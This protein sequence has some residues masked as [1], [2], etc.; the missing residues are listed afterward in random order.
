MQGDGT[1]LQGRYRV[2]RLE[3]EGGMSFVYK[4]E[5]ER[6]NKYWALK[7]LKAGVEFLDDSVEYAQFKTEARI[8]ADFSHPAFPSVID[9]FLDA[10]KAYI[11]EEWI[12]GKTL[13][14]ICGGGLPEGKIREF[15]VQLLDALDYIHKKGVVYRDL[16]PQNIMITEGGRIKLIDFG[17]ARFYKAGKRKD[18]VLAGT[19]GYAPPEQYGRGQTDIRTDIYSLGATIYFMITGVHPPEEKFDIQLPVEY[20]STISPELDRALKKA[21]KAK[22]DERF[23][24]LDGFR[25]SLD[26]K[27]HRGRT[28]SMLLSIIAASVFSVFLAAEARV[29]FLYSLLLIL[30]IYGFVWAVR[31]IRKGSK[32]S[33]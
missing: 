24:T 30:L 9:F 13:A 27:H 17:I 23:Q 28:K 31:E 18:T 1:V 6:L 32:R 7:E 20:R 4:V 5:D 29:P 25:A 11:V 33:G 22:P 26:K 3:S 10:G 19:P 15:T 21:M 2:V 14:S 16:K 8:L 12:E